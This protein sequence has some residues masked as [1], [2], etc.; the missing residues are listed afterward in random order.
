MERLMQNISYNMPEVRITKSW[1]KSISLR[2]D[3]DG[4]LQVKAP[5]FMT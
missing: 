3:R 2:F 1:R 4:V 5:K